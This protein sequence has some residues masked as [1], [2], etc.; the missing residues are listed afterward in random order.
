MKKL[1]NLLQNYNVIKLKQFVFYIIR[2]LTNKINFSNQA[3]KK[4]DKKYYLGIIGTN[5]G[6]LMIIFI[7]TLIL[8]EILIF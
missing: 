8:N 1:Y 4:K 7:F 3:L 5:N 2:L 6:T